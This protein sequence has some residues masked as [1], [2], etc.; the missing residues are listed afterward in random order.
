VIQS[1]LLCCNCCNRCVLWRT[2]QLC[3]VLP[4]PKRR[5]ASFP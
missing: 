4:H 5:S 2:C 1:A 3:F